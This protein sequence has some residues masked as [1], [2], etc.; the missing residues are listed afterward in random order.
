MQQIPKPFD[1]K[2]V[3]ALLLLIASEFKRAVCCRELPLPLSTHPLNSPGLV[4]LMPTARPDRRSCALR[5][6]RRSS[7]TGFTLWLLQHSPRLVRSDLHLVVATTR[8]P[9]QSRFH[10][11]PL[12]FCA[13]EKFRQVMRLLPAALAG[14]TTQHTLA[15]D[16]LARCP[17][18]NRQGK[19][20]DR[21]Q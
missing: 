9:I 14:V 2:V 20:Q 3:V 19:W 8:T 15:P 11:V 18:P 13:D 12:R 4:C 1:D 7:P 5:R 17:V 16:G 21:R 6:D 10:L